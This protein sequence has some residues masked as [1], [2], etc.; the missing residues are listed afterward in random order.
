MIVCI[1]K[2]D[3]KTVNYSEG[4]YKDIVTETKLF[5]KKVGYPSDKLPYIPISGWTGDNMLERSTVPQFSW[6]KG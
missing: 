2:V 6:Y 3:E 1:N 5:L 4:R